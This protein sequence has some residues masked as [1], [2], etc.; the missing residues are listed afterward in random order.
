LLSSLLLLVLAP[1][2]TSAQESPP[3]EVS[4]QPAAETSS[5]RRPPPGTFLR[6]PRPPRK[7]EVDPL[8]IDLETSSQVAL[9]PLWPPLTLLAVSAGGGIIGTSVLLANWLPHALPHSGEEPSQGEKRAA[10]LGLAGAVVSGA[11]FVGSL[12]WLKRRTRQRRRLSAAAAPAP[13]AAAVSWGIVGSG[14]ELR[15]RL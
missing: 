15:L 6:T 9:P 13:S 3:S 5:A 11:A 7:R 4:S 2:R 10:A 12:I 1:T 14:L 8:T